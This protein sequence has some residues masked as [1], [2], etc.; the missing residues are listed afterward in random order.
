MASEVNENG[1][2][3]ADEIMSDFD[4]P[5]SKEEFPGFIDESSID[6]FI[7]NLDDWD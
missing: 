4:Y 7:A 3:I 5:I 6:D 2:P 1:E